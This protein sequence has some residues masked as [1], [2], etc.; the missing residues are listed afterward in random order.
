M[1]PKWVNNEKKM[2]S[3]KLKYEASKIAEKSEEYVPILTT[4]L[5]NIHRVLVQYLTVNVREI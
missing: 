4:F 3:H 1:K 5:M 2:S